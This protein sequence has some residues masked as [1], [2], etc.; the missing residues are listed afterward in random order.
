MWT[1]K[2]ESTDRQFS[3]TELQGRNIKWVI[4][5]FLGCG[6]LTNQYLVYYVGSDPTCWSLPILLHIF[7]YSSKCNSAREYGVAMCSS[8]SILEVRSPSFSYI[9]NPYIR[10]TP[11]PDMY[12]AVPKKLY[13]SWRLSQNHIQAAKVYLFWQSASWATWFWNWFS[14][15]LCAFATSLP[16]RVLC[17]LLVIN[18]YWFIF[19]SSWP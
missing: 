4:L 6:I 13:N 7:A 12:V 9:G 8:W 16:V 17:F 2:L 11:N 14:W 5:Y 10:D 19:S 1:Q 15:L 18:N 3:F